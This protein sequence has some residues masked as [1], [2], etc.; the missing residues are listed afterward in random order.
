[1]SVASKGYGRSFSLDSGCCLSSSHRHFFP[2]YF[3]RAGVSPVRFSF[4]WR[5][6][7]GYFR[8]SSKV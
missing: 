2:Q 8:I 7:C 1:M 3:F 5:F 4:F 6:V